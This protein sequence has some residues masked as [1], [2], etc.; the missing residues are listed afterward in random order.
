MCRY[1]SH[2]KQVTQTPSPSSRKSTE[3]CI[4]STVRR[5]SVASTA[6]T[7][8]K[9]T[10][11]ST[12]CPCK[13]SLRSDE[14]R[15]K[16]STFRNFVQNGDRRTDGQTDTPPFNNDVVSFLF[17]LPKL[18]VYQSLTVSVLMFCLSVEKSV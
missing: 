11:S 13:K 8:G 6:S 12:E 14:K 2:I 16:Y 3:L 1:K 18:A 10:H 5:R 7:F 4:T 17:S 15:L 9:A